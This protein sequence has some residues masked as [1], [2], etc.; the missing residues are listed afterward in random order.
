MRYCSPDT[1][2]TAD[3][4]AFDGEAR[5][6][7]AARSRICGLQ[8]DF[9]YCTADT[10]AQ[11]PLGRRAHPDDSA[12]RPSA[13]PSTQPPAFISG[14]GVRWQDDDCMAACSAAPVPLDDGRR[15]GFSS[16]PYPSRRRSVRHAV[17]AVLLGCS[18][19]AVWL[20]RPRISDAGIAGW[21]DA[22]P[23]MPAQRCSTR[24]WSRSSG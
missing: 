8:V 12:L 10:A 15:D 23:A 6:E 16:P 11:H 3:H 2:L 17:V 14:S 7:H 5:P 13:T 18:E 4:R 1:T 21:E 20:W 9:T 24:A 22:H 19:P